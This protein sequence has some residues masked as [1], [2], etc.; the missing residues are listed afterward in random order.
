LEG[1]KYD[2]QDEQGKAAFNELNTHT[3][4]QPEEGPKQKQGKRNNRNRQ[5]N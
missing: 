3:T 1:L 2:K 4:Q 5:E